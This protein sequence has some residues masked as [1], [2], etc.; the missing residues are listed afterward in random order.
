MP[1]VT[2]WGDIGF[3]YVDNNAPE[4]ASGDLTKIREVRGSLQLHWLTE[5]VLP[6]E[7]LETSSTHN[8]G[9]CDLYRGGQSNGLVIQLAASKP[10][11]DLPHGLSQGYS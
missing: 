4:V 11:T 5:L 9:I 1:N 8:R 2:Y 10:L 3:P 6:L 7:S